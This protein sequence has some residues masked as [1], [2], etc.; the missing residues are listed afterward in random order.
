MDNDTMKQIK[1]IFTDMFVEQ[2]KKYQSNMMPMKSQFQTW[3]TKTAKCLMKGWI[4]FH[5][6]S[7]EI[8]IQS[9]SWRIT[10]ETKTRERDH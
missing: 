4:T 7:E 1:K 3:L 8:T 9:S 10:L 5:K 6:R 2:Y